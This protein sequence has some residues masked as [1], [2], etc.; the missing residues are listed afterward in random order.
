[1]LTVD[2]SE[3]CKDIFS[4]LTWLFHFALSLGDSSISTEILF[5]RTVFNQ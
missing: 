4:G 2:A 5:Q 1:M 3:G